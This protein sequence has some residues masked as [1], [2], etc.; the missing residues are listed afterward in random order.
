MTGAQLVFQAQDPRWVL[1]RAVRQIYH[2][3]VLSLSLCL[4]AVEAAAAVEAQEEEAAS[5]RARKGVPLVQDSPQGLEA[6]AQ[7]LAHKARARGEQAR[8]QERQA[9]EQDQEVKAQAQ[10]AR[11]AA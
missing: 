5:L 11:G 3:A 1:D 8:A 7:V 6:W 4:A 10:Q 9:R 2:Q